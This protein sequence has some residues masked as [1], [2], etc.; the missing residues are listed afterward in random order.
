M[1]FIKIVLVLSCFAPC[2]SFGASSSEFQNATRLLTA[3]RH[4]DIQT[5]Q[6]LIN[7]GVD[8]NYVDSTGLSLVCTA[9]MNNDTRTIQILQMYGADASNCDRQIKDYKRKTRIAADGE[10]GGFFSGLSSTHNLALAAV[11]GIAIVG[12][13]LWLTDAFD[14]K[15]NNSSSSSGGGGHG[16]GGGGGGGSGTATKWFTVP[17]GPAYLNSEGEVNPNFDLSTN[18]VAWDNNSSSELRKSDFNYL[19]KILS[20]NKSPAM[21]DGINSL[22]ENYLLDMHGYHSFASG[23]MGQDTFRNLLSNVPLLSLNGYQKEPVQIGLITGNGINPAGSADF[24][25]GIIY[26]NS[27]NQDAT[28]TRIDKYANNTISAI[29]DNNVT[30]GYSHTE[31]PGFDLSGSGSVFNPYV[32]VNDSALAKIVAGW[33]GGRASD[34]GDLYGFVPNG[35]LAIYRTGA[36]T[37]WQVIP[38]ADRENVGTY[39]DSGTVGLSDGDVIVL[40]GHTYNISVAS[41]NTLTVG[42]TTYDLSQGRTMFIGVCDGCDDDIVIYVGAGTGTGGDGV[43]Y[44]NSLGGNDIDSV[45]KPVDGDIYTY[46]TKTTGVVYSNFSAMQK[47]LNNDVVANVSV[48][49]AS[50]NISYLTV[51]NFI[52]AANGANLETFYKQQI[53]NAYG[54]YISD[55]TPYEQGSVAHSMFVGYT[56]DAM[57][58]MPAGDY[59]AKDVVTNTVYY[60]TLNATFEN[61]A[62]MLYSSTLKHKF[63][64]VV[65]VSHANG[66]S[67]ADTISS[68]G[69]G[70]GANFGKL[71]L[72]YWVDTDSNIYASRKCGL[73]G[74]GN[75]S[76]GVDPWCF[77]A[78]GPTAEMATASAAGA[79]ASVKSAFSYMNNDQIF[80]LLALTADGPYLSTPALP[81]DSTVS[82]GTATERLANYL[83]SMYQLPLEYSNFV[84]SP[85]EYLEKFKEVF[86]YGLI[87]L[88]RAIMP[89]FSIYYYSDGN[90]VSTNGTKNKYWNRSASSS[91]ASTVLSLT[92]RSSITASF[93]DIVE[94][95]DGSLS[96]PRVW[97]NTLAMDNGGRRGLYMGNVLGDFN[98]D[99]DNKKSHK[100]GNFEFSMST[101]LREY[102]DNLNGL[103]NLRV[104]FV[105]DDYNVAAEYQHHLTNGQ[106]RFNGR[107]NGLLSL[108]SDA[109]LSDVDYKI[110]NFA[111]GARAFSGAITDESLLEND[112]TVSAQ[113]EPGRLGLVNGGAFDA[114]YA[115]DKFGIDLSVGV[116][117]ENNTVLGM[118]SDGLLNM[119]GGNT[120]YV[121]LGA[122]YKP[123]DN[124]KLFM[125][126]MFANTKVDEFGGLISRVSNIKSNEFALG[127]DVGNFGLTIAMPLAVADGEI[128]YYYA[129]FDVAENDGAYNIVMNNPHVEYVDLTPQKREL[130]FVGE[131]KRA[132][133]DWTNAGVEFMYR[134]NPNNTNVFGNES[135]LMFKV[136][137]RMGI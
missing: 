49:P 7:M 88:E 136:H 61:Y 60:D 54:T 95:V 56:A 126:G 20:G 122:T 19:R 67:S 43:W 53:T 22:L 45:Y 23:Y 10:E 15:N 97:T 79:V 132:L 51:N 89:G 129:E 14:S 123:Y 57:L 137:H 99:F 69:D 59:L 2:V 98:V 40:N 46:K 36:G 47:A 94:S 118:Y 114:K 77:A 93:Y 74:V 113:F 44:V 82:S 68:Y 109:M 102:N 33:E 62:P 115:T 29:I 35:Q 21:L 41:G 80:T 38:E 78:S 28:L 135:V 91:H 81:V 5:V 130:R 25:D 127:A 103:D 111:F 30:I 65:G 16:G 64:T 55:D 1:K 105:T 112:P 101:S 66:N 119:R 37:T 128:G 117:R 63:M 73:A 90:I 42:E 24:S 121:D 83:Q 31:E 75:A 18:L 116:M 9:V 124:V 87:N 70:T 26:A 6:N 12:G 50:K 133:G 11:G 86:G 8:I 48:T 13:L 92:P 52:V 120:Q 4:G 110:G 96:L 104:A 108:T 58:V 84:F 34:D 32:N 125:R 106:S 134:V 72:S 3:A 39:T 131:Y 76:G 100:I 17:Y 85:D 71:Q 107:A 27:I